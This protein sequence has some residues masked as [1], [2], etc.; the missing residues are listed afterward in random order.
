VINV[1]VSWVS[2]AGEMCPQHRTTA[3]SSGAVAIESVVAMCRQ[4]FAQRSI[5]EFEVNDLCSE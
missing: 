5:L 1:Y 2:K 3:G 4:Y